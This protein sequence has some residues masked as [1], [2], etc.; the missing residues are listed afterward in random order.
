MITRKELEEAID[1]L[2]ESPM[3]YAN[4]QK[5][6][7]FYTIYDH[8]YTEKSAKIEKIPEIVV[9]IQGESAFVKAINGMDSVKAWEIMDELMSTLSLLDATLYRSVMR[10][11]EK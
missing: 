3:S 4:L 5:L 8:M 11:L 1:T 2:V 6:A 7:T 10:K 9:D